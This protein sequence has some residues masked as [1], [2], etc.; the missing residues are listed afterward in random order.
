MRS[1]EEQIKF[2]EWW[3]GINFEWLDE[4][5]FKD[6]VEAIRQ[7]SHFGFMDQKFTTE[8][9]NFFIMMDIIT[10]KFLDD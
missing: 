3:D 8:Q 5:T 4:R 2:D 1:E 7:I 6:Y 10:S 9:T